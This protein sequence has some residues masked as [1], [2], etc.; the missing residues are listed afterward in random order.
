MHP[1]LCESFPLMRLTIL[2]FLLPC[3]TAIADDVVDFNRDVRPILANHCWSCHGRDEASRKAGLRL[4]TRDAALAAGDS[5][6]PAIV[7]GQPASSALLHRIHA[8]DPAEIMPPPE[9]QK[10][11]SDRQKSVLQNW[12]LQGA[13]Y[14]D[15]WAFI[16]PQRPPLP[17][18]QPSDWP[19]S[20]LDLFVL[21]RLQQEGLQPSA[22]ASPLMWLR[23]ASLDLTGISPSP[24]EQQQFLDDVTQQGLLAAKSLAANRLLQS[25]RC[26]ERLAMQW[27]D[28][29]RYADTN[30]YNNDEMRTMWPC[31]TGSSKPSAPECPGIS[32]SSNNW[33]V[34]CCPMPP[35]A[36]R[37][38]PD[39]F[40]ITY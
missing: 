33:P 10:P 20:E 31:A 18:V 30:G 29:A 5:G 24:T 17:A 1:L 34:I 14:A 37:L 26:A 25:D 6:Q 21:H 9:L 2:A 36:R 11:L 4:D 28:A 12:I 7:P 16:P 32:S 8:P 13:P 27:L 39:S 19:V 40:A 38:P 3:R 23:R 15:H 22:P 35:S